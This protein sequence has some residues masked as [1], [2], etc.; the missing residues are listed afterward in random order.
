VKSP[1]LVIEELLHN[2]TRPDGSRDDL[3]E[4][5]AARQQFLTA[6]PAPSVQASFTEIADYVRATYQ[7]VHVQ[8]FLRGADPWVIAHARDESGRVVT[9]EVR[10]APTKSVKRAKIP[11]VCDHFGIECL[12]PYEML[13]RLRISL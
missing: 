2:G 10:E 4:W 8:T 1:R 7:A 12:T 11:D 13:R 5:V 6:E 3:A 9:L